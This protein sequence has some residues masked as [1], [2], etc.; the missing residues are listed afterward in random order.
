MQQ[1]GKLMKVEKQVGKLMKVEEK[2]MKVVEAVAFHPSLTYH[3]ILLI[4][5]ETND[6]VEQWHYWWNWWNWWQG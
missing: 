2:L 5:C 6:E 4:A 1:V 3:M